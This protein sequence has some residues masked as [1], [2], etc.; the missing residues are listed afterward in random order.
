M[1]Q[2][3][4]H[5]IIECLA[6]V[7]ASVEQTARAVLWE[8]AP[9]HDVARLL[10]DNVDY[11][12]DRLIARLQF[13]DVSPES[14]TVFHAILTVE[15]DIGDLLTHLMPRVYELLDTRDSFALPILRMLPL[16]VGKLADEA[17][18]VV[19]RSI[20]FVLAPS[21]TIECAALDA[22]NAAL[23]KFADEEN[24]LPMIHQMWAPSL[25]IA[26][27]VADCSNPASRRV[28]GVVTAALRAARSFVRMRVREMLPMLRGFV[29]GNLDKLA[30]NPKHTYA[31]AMLQ[32]VLE[33]MMEALAPKSVF[34][35]MELEVFRMLVMCFEDGVL[36][37]VRTAAVKCLV[38]LY[39]ESPAFVW[40]LMLEA[41][42]C[43]PEGDIKPSQYCVG[44]SRSVRAFF[45]NLLSMATVRL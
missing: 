1:L 18:N 12:A 11:I 40:A 27:S 37:E 6:A 32:A 4:L 17:H 3:F 39:G 28:I 42:Q 31:M 26:T 38:K 30:E 23:P 43:Y 14:L 5:H 22:I 9:N 8:I 24:L 10:R 45:R 25:R 19:D 13:V 29:E 44:M 21:A 16:V 20:H 33:L 7:H 35:S 15:G 34:D 2:A 36:E 41:G